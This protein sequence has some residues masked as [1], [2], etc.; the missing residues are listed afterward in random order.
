MRVRKKLAF[1]ILVGV[2][3]LGHGVCRDTPSQEN[4]AAK[5]VRLKLF[6]HYGKAITSVRIRSDSVIIVLHGKTAD[7]RITYEVCRGK[8]KLCKDVRREEQRRVKNSRVLLSHGLG[9]SGK[10]ENWVTKKEITGTDALSPNDPIDV[11]P[12]N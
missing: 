8:N 3:L 4:A 1:F 11:L 7:E 2:A 10:E 12:V 9:L 6:Q 5:Q